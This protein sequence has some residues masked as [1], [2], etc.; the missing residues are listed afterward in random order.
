MSRKCPCKDCTHHDSDCHA[1]CELYKEYR[2][3]KDAERKEREKRCYI[4]WQ[5]NAFEREKYKRIK[6][7]R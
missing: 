3:V 7:S 5:L 1:K 2:A 6:N 4:A